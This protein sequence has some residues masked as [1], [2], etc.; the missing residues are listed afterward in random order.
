MRRIGH[1]VE[2]V[3]LLSTLALGDDEPGFLELLEVLHHPEASHRKPGLERAQGLPVLPKQ[4]VEEAAPG[5]I[6]QCLEHCVHVDT[7]Y[8]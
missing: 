3:V 7:D 6:G 4:L 8:T 2:E 1:G 5:G